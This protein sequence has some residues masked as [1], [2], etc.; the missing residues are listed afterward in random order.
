MTDVPTTRRLDPHRRRGRGARAS[1][2]TRCAAGSAT[3]ASSSSAAASSATCPPTSWPALLRERAREGRPARATGCS[4]IVLGVRRDGVM[5][6]IDM[7]CGPYRVVSL[8]SREA[9]DDLGL[10]PGDQAVGADQVDDGGRRDALS[11][12]ARAGGGSRS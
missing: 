4:G 3:G 2:S 6:Q 1:A 5:A 8:M 11:S 12:G 9:A 10:Q 7:A